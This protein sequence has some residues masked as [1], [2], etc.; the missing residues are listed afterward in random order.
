MSWKLKSFKQ[1]DP[2]S[3]AGTLKHVGEALAKEWFEDTR[4]WSEEA[5]IPVIRFTF[6][7]DVDGEMTTEEID[8]NPTS[9]SKGRL[10]IMLKGMSPK[11]WSEAVR[12]NEAAMQKFA[13]G[14]VGKQFLLTYATNEK[15]KT[16][17]SSII[18][19]PSVV[20]KVTKQEPLPAVDDD[21]IPF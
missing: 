9:S 7:L 4:T 15:G 2:G 20:S 8:C 13:E 5:T 11:T 1:K 6:D 17:F 3:Y 16:R 14:L 19:A 12:I 21:D 10:V 18:P